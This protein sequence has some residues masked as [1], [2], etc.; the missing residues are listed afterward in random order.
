MS[1]EMHDFVMQHP[2]FSH[3][4]HH[5]HFREFEDK[6]L[7]YDE[8]SLLGYAE[9]DLETAA[10]LG[11]HRQPTARARISAHWPRIATTGY[12]R[13]VNLGCK[14]LFGLDYSPANF[15]AITE[16]LQSAFSKRTPTEVYDYFVKEK[17][18]VEWVLQDGY[19]AP[20]NE[21]LLQDT[22]YPDYYRFAW[23][24]DALF[25][26]DDAAPIGLLERTTDTSINTL[27]DLVGAMNTNI[28]T[29]RNTG[30][31]AAFKMGIA[32]L[33]DLVIGDPARRE[34]ELA[35]DRIRGR[36]NGGT[37]DAMNAR[38]LS[39][40]MIRRLLQ[41]A[42]DESIPVQIHT[43]YLAG[44]WGALAGTKALHLIPV[45]ERYR[46]VRF[47]IFHAS[48]PWTSELGAIAKNYPNVYPDMCWVWAMNPTE[49]ERT[50]GEWLDGVPF[51]KIF[52]FGADTGLPWCEVG[53]SIQARLGI[54]R[55]LE[56]KI[57]K[58][59]F[60]KATAEEVA[61][62]IMLKNGEQFYGVA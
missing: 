46:R 40:F 13:A 43:G 49:S 24:M 11:E 58:G 19:F 8:T 29:F 9:A 36:E 34:A 30:K 59:F 61:S 27:D 41:R 50:L 16:A 48:W 15:P 22:M 62:A 25:A 18:G 32:Y 33:R 20:G 53:Y 2:L 21:D 55:V 52:A 37:A 56:E 38:S 39:D 26:I 42:S 31:L 47:D 45:F 57:R 51:N 7:E 28:N 54:A 35:F 6:R 12:G 1:S 17:A 23:R 44:N 10:G 60:S 14:A 5:C 3:H 4:D